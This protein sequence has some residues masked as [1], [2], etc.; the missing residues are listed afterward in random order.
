M[1][2]PGRSYFALPVP[3]LSHVILAGCYRGVVDIFSLLFYFSFVLHTEVE[4]RRE[5]DALLPR[6]PGA[7]VPSDQEGD[8]WRQVHENGR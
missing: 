3:V 2:T 1:F 5:A 4:E 8:M 6:Q 7:K